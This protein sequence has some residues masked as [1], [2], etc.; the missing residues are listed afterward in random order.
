M[1]VVASRARLNLIW[2]IRRWQVVSLP[3]KRGLARAKRAALRFPSFNALL[4][5]QFPGC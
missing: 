5:A 1:I 3:K 4:P 2:K